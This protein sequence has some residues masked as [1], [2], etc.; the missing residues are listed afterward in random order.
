MIKKSFLVVIFCIVSK[1]VAQVGIGTTDIDPS[2]VLELKSTSKGFLMP[3]MTTAE[4]NDITNPEEG[5]VVYNTERSAIQFFRENVGANNDLSGW[6]DTRCEND[7]SNALANLPNGIILDFSDFDNNG[8]LF[9]DVDG[10]GSL[11]TTSSPDNSKVGSIGPLP[12]D[13]NDAVPVLTNYISFEDKNEPGDL[14]NSDYVFR[15]KNNPENF[16]NTYNA[17][18]F[19]TRTNGYNSNQQTDL[20]IA[21][22]ATIYSGDFDLLIVAKYNALPTTKKE[23]FFSGGNILVANGDDSKNCKQ[24]HF[25][26]KGG[27]GTLYC[28]YDADPNLDKRVEVDTEFHRFRVKY[29]SATQNVEFYIDGNLIESVVQSMDIDRFGLFINNG[30]KFAPNSAI[31][32]IGL[33]KTTLSDDDFTRFDQ[34]LACKFELQP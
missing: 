15:L 32:F 14:S 34:Y 7:I 31:A 27:A 11:L 20:F 22:F 8:Q 24:N 5:L 3:R 18:S 2:A 12:T 13:L 17:S 10:M 29:E 25:M 28:G 21:D 33:F 6:Y 19:L 4:R 9:S 23:T 30:K 16:P 26:I 1:S